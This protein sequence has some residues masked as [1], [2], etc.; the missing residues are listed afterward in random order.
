VK[1][2]CVRAGCWPRK[3]SGSRGGKY[4]RGTKKTLE[5]S[6]R[7]FANKKVQGSSPRRGIELS[8]QAQVGKI[9]A[10]STQKGQ[11]NSTISFK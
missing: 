10:D 2:P 1:S 7:T 5:T 11:T 6:L 3:N 4:K 9:R 8:E